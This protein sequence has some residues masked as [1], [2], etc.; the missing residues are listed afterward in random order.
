MRN[1]RHYYGNPNFDAMYPY[2]MMGSMPHNGFSRAKNG[3][4]RGLRRATGLGYGENIVDTLVEKAIA[5]ELETAKNYFGTTFKF[6]EKDS[7]PV[8][9][10]LFKY[11]PKFKYHIDNP[12]VLEGSNITKQSLELVSIS[13]AEFFL[14][15][16][17][18]TFAYVKSYD[19]FHKYANTGVFFNN[20]NNNTDRP[21]ISDMV[22]YIFGRYMKKYVKELSEMTS[23]KLD[24]LCQYVVMGGEHKNEYSITAKEINQRPIDSL[25]FDTD[26][27]EQITNH[28][29]T[30]LEN[31][32]LYADRSLLFKTGILLQGDP[33]TGKSSLVIALAT[34]YNMEIINI[35]MPSFR[36]ID[37]ERVI[38]SINADQNK[39]IVL[40]EEIDCVFNKANR[41][42]GADKEDKMYISDLLQFIDSPK[43][44]NNVIFIATTNYPDKLDPALVRKGRFDLIVNVNNLKSWDTVK[45]MCKSFNLSENQIDDICGRINLPIAQSALQY[46]IL[47]TIKKETSH[48]DDYDELLKT[49]E[50]AEGFIEEDPVYMLSFNLAF[51]KDFQTVET[52]RFIPCE[53]LPDTAKFVDTVCAATDGKIVSLYKGNDCAYI[54]ATHANT[55]VLPEDCSHM[56]ADLDRCKHII[57]DGIN[58]DVSKVKAAE[59][60]FAGTDSLL[61]NDLRDKLKMF[62]VDAESESDETTGE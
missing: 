62:Y 60:I 19:Q 23:V 3:L 56:F 22:I 40:L 11:D 5:K 21:G 31:E 49:E 29:D 8:I 2:P 39:Y 9:K 20:E 47:A 4:M 58:V 38:D 30:W 59:G 52:V 55:I 61:R 10:W 13:N 43:S 15:L 6:K 32:Q 53:K 24:N 12:Q 35:N 28:I 7:V 14:I 25:F 41:E 54:V 37:I 27:K 33:G 26:V 46:E 44:P 16:D 1:N 36:N 34:K 17:R 42:D 48:V 45:E 50:D 18:G 57:I 51:Y